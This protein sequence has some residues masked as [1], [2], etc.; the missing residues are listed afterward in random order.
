MGISY[1]SQEEIYNPDFQK[2]DIQIIGVGS[3]GSFLALTLAKMGL[4]DIKIID[5]DKVENHN[6]PNQFYKIKD[7]N[8][9]KLD[10]LKD[11]IKEFSDIE[12][13]TENIKIDKNYSFD[14][15][16]NTIV[17]ICVDNMESREIIFN[18]LKDFPIKKLI[19]TR[20]GGEG[21]S[22]HVVDLEKEEEKERYEKS[23][24]LP[25]KET[26]CGE[27]GII[28]S[29]LSLSSEVCNIIKKIECGE[30][31]PKLLKRELKTYRFIV[32]R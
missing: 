17:L 32:R 6:I 26:P 7:E 15:G 13:K 10:A 1:M 29:I 22:I 8:K 11:I 27:K 9:E 2:S 20:F 25:I 28:Y 31:Y 5:Y 3:T 12:I 19:D 30:N 21:F 4:K 18:K 14:V 16:L 23:L 24:K